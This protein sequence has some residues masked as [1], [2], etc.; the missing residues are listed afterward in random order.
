M[1]N[2]SQAYCLAA[3]TPKRLTAKAPY[4][5]LCARSQYV[6]VAVTG[7]GLQTLSN[8]LRRKTRCTACGNL[9]VEMRLPSHVSAG[10]G[11]QHVAEHDWGT[12]VASIVLGIV[13]LTIG[14][15]W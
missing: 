10:V 8:A 7:Y 12:F 9:G 4:P 5:I 11:M 6:T 14:A 15:G 1:G 2:R 3:A 13:R